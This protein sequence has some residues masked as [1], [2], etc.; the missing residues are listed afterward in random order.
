MITEL[1]LAPL[2]NDVAT[3]LGMR[4]HRPIDV[5]RERVQFDRSGRRSSSFGHLRPRVHVLFPEDEEDRLGV[6]LQRRIQRFG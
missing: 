4:Q 1:A 2:Q 3:G 6:L 5:G